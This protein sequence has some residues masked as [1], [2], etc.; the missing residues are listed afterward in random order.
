MDNDEYGV[1]VH[2]FSKN[3]RE[4]IRIAINEFRG[5]RYI[6]VR[7]FFLDD[8]KYMP[9]K[10]GVTL[11]IDQYPELLSGI[12]QLGETLGYDIF[13]GGQNDVSDTEP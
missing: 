4:Q 5:S 13:A 6:D 3:A 9:T 12:I 11:A 2:S 10:K 8:N 7:I 1:L